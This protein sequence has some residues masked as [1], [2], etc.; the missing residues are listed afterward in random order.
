M[1]MFHLTKVNINKLG[2]IDTLKD[3]REL[4]TPIAK[5]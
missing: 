4:Q 5:M 1:N 2:Y 3:K